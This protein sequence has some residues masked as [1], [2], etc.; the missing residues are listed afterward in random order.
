MLRVGADDLKPARISCRNLLKGRKGAMVTLYRD[1]VACAQR[2]Q[3][4]RQ[5]AGAG[6]NLDDCRVFQGTRRARDSCRQVEVQKKI[7]AERF[8]RRHG[9]PA[10][11]FA[12][13]REIVDCTHAGWAAAIRAASRRAAIRLDGFALPVPAMSK[14]VP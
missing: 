1:H 13:R 11:N 4:A 3:R 12:K 8:A 14:A 5:S 7:L 10:N 9:V 6:A 2:E